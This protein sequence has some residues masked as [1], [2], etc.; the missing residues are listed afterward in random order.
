MPHMLFLQYHQHHQRGQRRAL[1]RHLFDF[2]L[3]SVLQFRL[4][5]FQIVAQLPVQPGLCIRAEIARQ[6]QC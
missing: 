3:D 2:A 4:G 5:D 6:P 1:R